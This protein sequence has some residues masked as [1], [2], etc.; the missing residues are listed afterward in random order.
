MHKWGRR[1]HWWPYQ[2]PDPHEVEEYQIQDLFQ[3][4]NQMGQWRMQQLGYLLVEWTGHGI[5]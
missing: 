1:E 4:I 5:Q 2:G 3:F